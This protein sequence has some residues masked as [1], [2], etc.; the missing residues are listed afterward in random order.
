M[1][2]FPLLIN[3]LAHILALS[4]A[5]GLAFALIVQPR[6]STINYLFTSVCVMLGLWALA[7]IALIVPDVGLEAADPGLVRLL[8][9]AQLLLAAAFFLFVLI[10]LDPRGASVRFLT[11]ALP[12]AVLIGL[13]LILGGTAGRLV[14][15]EAR[16]E[17]ES[18]G[19]IVL[20]IALGYLAISFWIILSS[21]NPRAA[22]LRGPSI[23]LALA[24]AAALINVDTDLPIPITLAVLAISWI[25]WGVL[26]FQVFNPLN[27]LN[28]EMRIANRDLQQ[29]IADLA[30]EKEKTEALNRDLRDANRYKSEF[31]ANMSHELRTP[32]N[33]II[34]YSE[35]LRNGLYGQLTDKQSDRVEKIHRNGQ[36]LLDLISD[37][38]DINKIDAGK[39]KLDIVAFDLAPI[40]DHVVMSLEPQRA[41]KNL[42]LSIALE[43]N[44]PQLYGDEK[45][46]RQVLENL[47]DNAIKFTPSGE[48]KIQAQGIQ[49]RGGTSNEFRLPALGWLRDGEWVL[50]S[51]IDTGIG[52]APEDQGRIFEEFAQLD[53]SRTREFGGTGLGLSIAKRLVEMHDGALWVKSARGEGSTFFVA[54]PTQFKTGAPTDSGVLQQPVSS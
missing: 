28:N 31:L 2:G 46:V 3:S 38:L 12:V 15:S 29:V 34:G 49:V 26:R 41:E 43:D 25:G 5:C 50:I 33:S 6:R 1:D 37:I 19:L 23:L 18:S 8:L 54:L 7:G 32:L 42:D 14:E 48:V 47:V 10:F 35:L 53:G 22:T 40:I 9:S 20:A 44:L 39:M 17:W 52:I 4:L 45:R 16:L 36:H 30:A 21:S 11:L 13:G 51:V 27:E 24:F